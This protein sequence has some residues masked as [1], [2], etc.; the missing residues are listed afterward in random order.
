[1]HVQQVAG[2]VERI[3]LLRR[4]VQFRCRQLLPIERQLRTLRQPLQYVEPPLPLEVEADFAF[5]RVFKLLF[6]GACGFRR[7]LNRLSC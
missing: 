3:I 2:L 5:G 4:Q 7:L 1:M 6:E